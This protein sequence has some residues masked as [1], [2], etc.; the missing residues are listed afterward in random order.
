MDGGK[1]RYRRYGAVTTAD[2]LAYR[3]SIEHLAGSSQNRYLAAIKSFF[4]WAQE[5]RLIAIDPA[6]GL[7][8]PRAILGKAPTYITLS[9]TETLLQSIK[10]GRYA[11]CDLVILWCFA[12]GLRVAETAS[13]NVP[14]VIHTP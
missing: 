9:E 5:S 3:Q 7:K 2:L 13:P 4:K 8:L 1:T 11:K 10:P 14:D 12:H 6:A